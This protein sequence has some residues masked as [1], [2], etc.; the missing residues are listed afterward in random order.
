MDA[1]KKYAALGDNEVFRHRDIADLNFVQDTLDFFTNGNYNGDDVRAMQ[2]QMTDVV[3]ELS[4]QIRAGEEPDLSK[5]QSKVT[6][7]GAEVSFSQ[8]LKFQEVGSALK[9]NLEQISLGQMDTSLYSKM[10]LAKSLGNYY[11]SGKGEIGA[12]FS[13]AMDRLYEKNGK[14]LERLAA[15]Q[16]NAA[17]Y[18]AHMT[19]RQRD[20]VKTAMA[21]RDTF[22]R[23]DTSSKENFS[24]DF[25]KKL[26]AVRSLVQNHCNQFH[27]P[28]SHVSLDSDTASIMKYFNNMLSQI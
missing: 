2:N 22:S 16:S 12:M 27:I 4:R 3:F 6:I 17:G 28:T 13:D 18:P 19:D 9:S 14:E 11:G 15:Y 20:A 5:L 10:G 21:V 25:S 24:K 23:L 26:D 7:K 1:A 8:L